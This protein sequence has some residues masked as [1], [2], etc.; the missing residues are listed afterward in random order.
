MLKVSWSSQDNESEH[1]F[2]A[3]NTHLIDLFYFTCAFHYLH[4]CK[5]T[6]CES[7]SA[8]SSL[9]PLDEVF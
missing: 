2:S 7:G 6:M 4:I 5:C 9:Q 1:V 8:E 3:K